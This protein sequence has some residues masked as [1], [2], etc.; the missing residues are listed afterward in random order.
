MAGGSFAR[1]K[2]RRMLSSWLRELFSP[3]WYKWITLLPKHACGMWD[4]HQV[5]KIEAELHNFEVQFCAQCSSED[6][7]V[8][9][10]FLFIY[11]YMILLVFFKI[12]LHENPCSCRST[13]RSFKQVG[14][15]LFKALCHAAF[16]KCS[17]CLEHII[18]SNQQLAWTA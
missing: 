14:V 15:A 18:R 6:L 3:P 17:N 9:L 8:C 13:R 4:F 2:G 5:W 16:D 1:L 10:F 7:H 11:I 12:K